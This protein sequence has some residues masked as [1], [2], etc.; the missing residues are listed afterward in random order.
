VELSSGKVFADLGFRDAEERMRN[1]QL[2][3]K[4]FQK[5]MKHSQTYTRTHES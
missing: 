1:A 4:N 5:S 2:A 3:I